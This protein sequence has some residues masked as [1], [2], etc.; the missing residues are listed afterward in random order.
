[1]R[2][3][4]QGSRI[5]VVG[6]SSLLGK[7]LVAVLKERNF[8]VARLVTLEDEE[9][10]PELPIVDLRE[11]IGASIADENLGEEDFD[12]VFVAARPA[13]L[14][15]KTSAAGEVA[16]LRS[17]ERL[18]Q[19]SQCAVIDAGEGL[20]GDPS[21]AVVIP[22]LGGAIPAG[23]TP[24][25]IVSPH[26]AAIVLAAL[27]LRLAAHF[28]LRTAVAQILEPVSDLGP[29]AVEELQHQATSLLT[30]Q[31]VPQK[32]FGQQLAF[33]VL[34]RIGRGRLK[35]AAG[36]ETQIHHHVREVLGG[37]APSPALRLLQAPVFHSLAVS[38]YVET[39]ERAPLDALTRA[40]AGERIEIRRTSETPPSQV[41]TSGSSTIFV[42]ALAADGSCPNGV[43]IW[44]VAD[45]LRLAAVNAVEIA[46]ALSKQTRGGKG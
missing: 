42:D 15:K 37:R 21:G 24:R 18:R 26:P 8:P 6:A 28:P 1:M 36:K 34:P 11:G 39:R 10:E 38:L 17:E 2:P 7:E 46:E 5:G 3:P 30:F 4:H 12:I 45:N 32:V 13:P 43:W 41:E 19:A 16:F 9:G 22:F 27:L 23:K 25:F 33:N 14:S 40:I 31:K 35:N 44:A 20:A 29:H